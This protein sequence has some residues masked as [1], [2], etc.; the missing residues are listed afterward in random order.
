[1]EKMIQGA[2]STLP[3]EARGASRPSKP[4]KPSPYAAEN[5][6]RLLRKASNNG[7]EPLSGPL[8]DLQDIDGLI[9][10]RIQEIMGMPLMRRVAAVRTASGKA[11]TP[12]K[13]PLP[14]STRGAGGRRPAWNS[15]WNAPSGGSG[16]DWSERPVGAAAGATGGGGSGGGGGGSGGGS[17]G[18]S[19]GGAGSGGGGN[20]SGGGVSGGVSGGGGL[21]GGVSGGGAPRGGAPGRATPGAAGSPSN[22]G[23][24][25]PVGP[26][27]RCTGTPTR[28]TRTASA[29]LAI[30]VGGT[31]VATMRQTGNLQ[32]AGER[33]VLLPSP[34]AAS[35][36]AHGVTPRQ[37]SSRY[38]ASGLR[39]FAGLGGLPPAGACAAAGDS[40]GVLERSTV[41]AIAAL[42][43]HAPAAQEAAARLG[44]HAPGYRQQGPMGR[45]DE[46]GGVTTMSVWA[47]G[48]GPCGPAGA[49]SG[50]AEYDHSSHDVNEGAY[51]AAGQRQR[52]QHHPGGSRSSGGAGGV[53]GG[54]PGVAWAEGTA[55]AAMQSLASMS[56]ATLMAGS[57]NAG[58]GGGSSGGSAGCATGA[59]T[60]RLPPG[61]PPRST[62]GVAASIAARPG[63]GIRGLRHASRHAADYGDGAGGAEE[64][65]E[66]EEDPYAD[67]A[68]EA[69]EGSDE[70]GGVVPAGCGAVHG[71]E[72]LGGDAGEELP[73]VALLRYSVNALNGLVQLKIQ[74]MSRSQHQQQQQHPGVA[75]AAAGAGHS[76]HHQPATQSAAAAGTSTTSP[77]RHPELLASLPLV[78][79][80]Q[81][82]Q[83][84]HH[85][86]HDH[87]NDLHPHLHEDPS[88]HLLASPGCG[89]GRQS[90][91]Q[92]LGSSSL[93][94]DGLR[95][96]DL[97]YLARLGAAELCGEE[98]EEDAAGAAGGGLEAG[99]EES[100]VWAIEPGAPAGTAKAWGDRHAWTEGSGGG[101]GGG[102]GG[103]SGGGA[104]GLQLLRERQE[105]ER[106]LQME[107]DQQQELQ[108]QQLPR[109]SGAGLGPGPQGG[110]G[111][112]ED[113]VLLGETMTPR[114]RTGGF[115]QTQMQAVSSALAA[116]AAS[117]QLAAGDA[118]ELATQTDALYG[119]LVQLHAL[120]TGPRGAELRQGSAS[121]SPE[122]A[123]SSPTEGFTP[124]GLSP[125]ASP[126]QSAVGGGVQLARR[127]RVETDGG[128]P[129]SGVGS[130]GGSG[131]RVGSSLVG[132]V[133]VA[134]RQVPLQV[135]TCDQRRRS[136]NGGSGGGAGGGGSLGGGAG[137]ETHMQLT[138][139]NCLVAEDVAW[140]AGLVRS[141]SESLH[142]EK[143][144]S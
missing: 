16:S 29:G 75:A 116:L 108:L 106:Q 63:E 54:T 83:A 48:R 74:E 68:F 25:A 86:H 65:E 135:E 24:R 22:S 46:S 102:G 141:I 30:E 85:H 138:P 7:R 112:E 93:M 98:E 4:K 62:T 39:G 134:A 71:E 82:Q 94:L 55:A 38:G 118:A 76:R 64:D 1:M 139:K 78:G 125:S 79:S 100:R 130:A 80:E 77:A 123:G 56:R 142:V 41:S 105:R 20:G 122:E 60:R 126:R 6:A 58:G 57:V 33:V 72:G 49:G 111:E 99:G 28:T 52:G 92:R 15:D 89:A 133:P 140:M 18:V 110:A 103:S 27:P 10:N 35:P 97:E 121:A 90:Q 84:H 101:G 26:P 144:G 13:P 37:A 117:G 12:S 95:Q 42:N 43:P 5:N 114:R 50:D 34:S 66:E 59:S 87:R 21:S 51:A 3:P 136:S 115:A 67:D 8:V 137:G 47:A 19:R 31:S 113:T 129:S 107:R 9:Y 131:S 44:P 88:G 119:S 2:K 61:M 14:L 81:Q 70:E 127:P 36:G 143:P 109:G 124:A 40:S 17:R 23:R 91:Q 53:A 45:N 96:S 132:G 32:T 120:M 128:G 73:D 11:G 69:Y 104:T